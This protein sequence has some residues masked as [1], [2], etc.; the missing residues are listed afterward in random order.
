MNYRCIPLAL[1]PLLF[2]CEDPK[3]PDKCRDLRDAVCDNAAEFCYPEIDADECEDVA[4]S[5]GFN[6]EDA[7]G[8]SDT[9]ESCLILLSGS[10]ECLL[11]D[12][13]PSVCDG[14]VFTD[15]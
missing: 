9:Y 4:R 14:V 3:A 15:E 13:L 5:A 8:V 6:C 11:D 1:A 10:D 7:W 12:D 2:G